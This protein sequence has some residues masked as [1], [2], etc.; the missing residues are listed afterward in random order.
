MDIRIQL[1][2][3]VRGLMAIWITNLDTK[4]GQYMQ[5]YLIFLK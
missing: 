3:D 1:T 4:I 5:T 2:K